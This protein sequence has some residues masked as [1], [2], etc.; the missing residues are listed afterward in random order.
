MYIDVECNDMILIMLKL[1]SHYEMV[2]HVAK[3]NFTAKYPLRCYSL[4][5][6]IYCARSFLMNCNNQTESIIR[7]LLFYYVDNT[8]NEV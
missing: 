7:H 8:R 4:F 2:F 6:A 1:N 3:L 5:D